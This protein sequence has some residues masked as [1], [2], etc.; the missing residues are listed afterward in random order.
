MRKLTR[1]HFAFLRAVVQGLPLDTV[2][3]RYMYM[4][5]DGGDLRRIRRTIRDLR[6]TLAA[7]ALRMGKPGTARLLRM[8]V[9]P[10][11][12]THIPTLDLF[13][14]ERGLEDASEAEQMAAFEA[15]FGQALQ[16]DR[17][18]GRIIARQLRA[19]HDLEDAA[20]AQP[21]ADDPVDA[22]LPVGMARHFQAAGVM[23]LYGL[24]RR[25]SASAHWWRRIPGV[26]QI[27]AERLQ[28]WM[29]EYGLLQ[30]SQ[31]L[32]A[33]TAMSPLLGQDALPILWERGAN[34]ATNNTTNSAAHWSVL[35]AQS[36]LEA[37]RSW[38]ADRQ[39]NTLRAYRRE[40]ERLILWA[41]IERCKP[42]PSWHAMICRT[43]KRFWP[44]SSR[45]TDGARCAHQPKLS[46][47]ASV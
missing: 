8:Q 26:G 32:M 34:S 24:A 41:A 4:E 29:Q 20:A 2:W 17:A 44:T 6:E 3:D 5:G 12:V 18:R 7:V 46:R 13:A 40:A 23:T 19:L 37:V 10:Q 9:P 15:E 35:G 14:A 33:R 27:K 11:A 47:L 38:L 1:D 22:W 31:D 28:R 39:G 36:D 43:T 21:K 42:C 45:Q 16:S 30:F 25:M